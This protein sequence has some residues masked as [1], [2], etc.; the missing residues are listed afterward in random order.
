MLGQI[1]LAFGCVNYLSTPDTSSKPTV[2]SRQKIHPEDSS[3][4]EMLAIPKKASPE[5]KTPSPMME[6]I[7]PK[8]SPLLASECTPTTEAQTM[9]LYGYN[10][11]AK[12]P[13]AFS[14]ARER[15]RERRS[16]RVRPAGRMVRS[17]SSGAAT[18]EP[19]RK[20]DRPR[21]PGGDN[22]VRG[23]VSLPG[24]PRGNSA[25]VPVVGSAESLVTREQPNQ[26]LAA[27]C[28]P[29]FVRNTSREMQEALEMT[30]EQMDR[31]AHQLMIQERNMKQAHNQQPQVGNTW[32]VIGRHPSSPVPP[33]PPA[34]RDAASI[35]AVIAS[36]AHSNGAARCDV[37]QDGGDH[38][39]DKCNGQRYN[40][41]NQVT[42]NKCHCQTRR[43]RK[44]RKRKPVLV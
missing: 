41:Y 16:V 13:F 27:Y 4:K 5:D 31:A 38:R 12:L 22:C 7:Q 3:S 28:D 29:E 14:H 33:L 30:Q 11:A 19:A 9:T 24:S 42:D 39:Y 8:I 15:A 25:S 2:V 21:S 34:G 20:V 36:A 1:G 32:A 35:Q 6:P 18:H 43:H 44:K 26:G 23:V 37:T 10:A 17:A 40:G